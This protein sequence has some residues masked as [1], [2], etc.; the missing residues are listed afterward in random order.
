MNPMKPSR[1]TTGGLRMRRSLGILAFLMAASISL[2][3][4]SNSLM[5]VHPNGKTLI[6]ANNDNGT[7][8]LVDLVTKEAVREIKVGKK[9]E[10][11]TW[12]GDGPL[13]A[14]TL[15]HEQSIVIFDTNTGK[16]EKTIKTAA[17]PYGIVADAK[18]TRAYVSHEYPG[19][20][21]EIDLQEGKVLREIPAGSMV[22]G[23]AIAPDGK[24]VYVSEF[25][26]GVLNAID[27]ASGKIVDSWK[28]HSTDNLARHV[29]LHPTRPKA[30]L[31]HIRSMIKI[32]DGAGSIFP[33]L[34]FCDLKPG[35]G[36]R[37]VAF[38]MDTFNSLYVV[39]NPWESAI[40]PDGKR[41]YLIY[42]GTND[43]NVCNVIDDDY[44]EVESAGYPTRT[45]QN[46]R[47][48]RVS[49]DSKS[50]YVYNAMDFSV[51]IY[52]AQTMAVVKNIKTCEQPKTPEWV[53]GKILFNT[54]N[55]PMSSR[56][57]VACSSC[58]PDGLH[59]G[60]VWQQAEGLRKATAFVGMANTHPLHWSADRDEVQDFE[61]TVRSKL[62]QGIGFL[63]GQ[64]K[65]KV[66]FH[67]AELEEK[68][69]GRSKDLDAIAIYCNSLEYPLS[70]HI[71]AP[72]KLKPAA[73]RGKDVFFRKDV[74]CA[75][76]HSGPYYTDSSLTQPFNL[77]DIGTG[78]GDK[79]ERMGTKFDT[80]TLLGIYRAS[81]YLHDGSAKTLLDVVTMQNK[82]DK[83]GKTS[84]LKT[85]E[86][87]D[88][89]E[90]L[91]S[92]PYQSPPEVTPNTVPFRVQ[93]M[94]KG[95]PA[96]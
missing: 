39:T 18:G 53:R 83:H 22:R 45:G 92:L 24:R 49:P 74:G 3:G 87:G 86:I 59:D 34:S 26:T 71:E 33:Q 94:K 43:M 56:R 36:R 73:M 75:T 17:E 76:C 30:Y 9:P 8:T 91:K 78:R 55:Q 88:L 61:Y 51:D 93:S 89:V 35:E 90:F 80:P 46:P 13:A 67:K 14:A 28:G 20:V 82:E 66:G 7:V 12:I 77:H 23:I 70:P 72:G 6:V 37:R 42:A 52:N 38:G 63:K 19:L 58:H 29:L 15:Y 48:V 96:R 5:D 25:Y 81:P 68:T 85:D 41:F 79:T 64:L 21:S 31:G 57:W 27:L 65:P 32:G 69:S 47:A 62:M 84:Q 50:V 1:I 95:D 60:R 54:A 16:I 44:K 40:S 4:P 10:G 2:A 11:V